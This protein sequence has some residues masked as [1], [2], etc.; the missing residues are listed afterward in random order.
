MLIVWGRRVEVKRTTTLGREPLPKRDFIDRPTIPCRKRASSAPPPTNVA[1]SPK[2]NEASA[3]GC[4]TKPLKPVR[5]ISS[6]TSHQKKTAKV[7]PN[8]TAT[9]IAADLTN[10]I[11][12]PHSN[13]GL[14]VVD[15]AKIHFFRLGED[16]V[17]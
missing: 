4:S 3:N 1:H 12:Q 7:R 13:N 11:L 14:T 16:L 9:A 17:D 5:Q 15:A 10:A 6:A 2:A 8:M